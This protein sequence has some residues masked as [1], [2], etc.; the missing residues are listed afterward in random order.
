MGALTSERTSRE[1]NGKYILLPLDSGQTAV[2][3]GG[4][5]TIDTATGTVKKAVTGVATLL[6]V[7]EFAETIPAPVSGQQVNVQLDREIVAKWYDNATGGNAIVASALGTSNAWWLDDHTVQNSAGGGSVAGRV[8][9]VDAIKG[10]LIEAV[11][12]TTVL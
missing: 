12:N 4:R 6:S 8:W 10:V 11:G 7:G 9:G 5:A 3:K 2:Y 1:F